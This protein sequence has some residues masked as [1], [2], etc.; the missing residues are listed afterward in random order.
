MV[1]Q[2]QLATGD[3]LRLVKDMQ[4]ESVD[5]IV[6]DPAYESLE[7]H[8]SVGTTTRLSGEW[9][10]VITNEELK[11][12]IVDCY[13]ILKNNAHCYIMCDQETHYVVREAAL[14]CG[15]TWKKFLVWDKMAISTGYSWRAKHEVICYLEKG[16]RNLFSNS[17]PD[18]LSHKRIRNRYPTEKP[19]SL[20]NDLILNSSKPGELV[21]DAFVGSGASMDAALSLGRDV[22]GFEKK[23]S[24]REG[25]ISRMEGNHPDAIYS[26]SLLQPRMQLQ[27]AV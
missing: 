22:I 9:F 3:S 14:A 11:G 13:R 17:L 27:L 23:E 6:T 5:L 16:K 24:Q 15:F 4:D 1:N 8:R 21:F 7:K 26:D 19:V 18:V 10:E 20:F 12:F 25:I 2:Y